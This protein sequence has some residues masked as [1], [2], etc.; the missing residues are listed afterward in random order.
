METQA[1]RIKILKEK[2]FR[3]FTKEPIFKDNSIHHFRIL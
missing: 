2:I 3:K 1:I